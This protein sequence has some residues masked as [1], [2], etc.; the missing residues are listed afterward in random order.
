VLQRHSNK[1][2]DVVDLRCGFAGIEAQSVTL[3][4][5][6]ALRKNGLI[7]DCDIFV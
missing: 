6:C 7:G 5:L 2:L 1:P 4:W 3:R